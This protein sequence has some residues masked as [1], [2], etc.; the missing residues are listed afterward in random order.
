MAAQLESKGALEWEVGSIV[1]YTAADYTE[2]GRRES[3]LFVEQVN[4]AQEALAHRR[5]KSGAA[6]GGVYTQRNAT[7]KEGRKESSGGA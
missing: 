2:G 7:R 6:A 1:P 4:F 5:S 3:L